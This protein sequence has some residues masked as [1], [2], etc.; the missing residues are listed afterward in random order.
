MK[1]F[2]SLLKWC[3]GL[4]VLVGSL[5]SVPA[6]GAEPYVEGVVR[7]TLGA[8]I[9]YATV[10]LLPES[11]ETGAVEDGAV[12][13]GSITDESG[14]YRIDGVAAGHYQL[15]CDHLSFVSQ[16]RSVVVR[17]G[18]NVHDFLLV[19]AAEAI[20]EVEVVGTTVQ[21]EAGKYSIRLAESAITKNKTVEETLKMLPGLS[22]V[23][24]VVK[25]DGQPVALVYI[26]DR[27]VRDVQ[28]LKALKGKYIESVEVQ[29]QTGSAYSATYQGGIVR[30]KLKK[31]AER[32]DIGSVSLSPYLAYGHGE[33][34]LS[35]GGFL[36]SV[37]FVRRGKMN[38]YN[39][40]S[41]G[42]NDV[43][44]TSSSVADYYTDGYRLSSQID[45]REFYGRVY[46]VFG[47]V[48]D[49]DERSDIG[50]TAVMQLSHLRPHNVTHSVSEM[51]SESE[52]VQL[53]GY[54]SSDYV[55]QTDQMR[56]EYLVGFNYN[57]RLDT[58]GSKLVLKA[59]Y[60]HNSVRK[61]ELYDTEWQTASG[62][63]WEDRYRQRRYV[64]AHMLMS[65][66]DFTK[67]LRAGRAIDAGLTYNLDYTDEW[68]RTE[69]WADDVWSEDSE[70]S[71]SFLSQNHEATAYAI[72]RDSYDKFSYSVGANLQW[73]RIAYEKSGGALT[74]RNY[75]QPFGNISV[76]YAINPQRGT[77]IN[78]DVSRY[79]S[80][81]PTNRQLSTYEERLSENVYYV[82]NEHLK[83][84]TGYRARLSYTLRSAWRFS[85]GFGVEKDG[86]YDLSWV[87]PERPEVVWQSPVNG[88]RAYSHGLNVSW[89]Q[90]VTDWLQCSVAYDCAWV[91][92]YY[93]D[94][95]SEIF[96][97]SGDVDLWFQLPQGVGFHVWGRYESPFKKL[98]FQCNDDLRVGFALDR[99][100]GKRVWLQ[101]N[102]SFRMWDRV[103]TNYQLD[104]S[105][106]MR[107]TYVASPLEMVGFTLSYDFLLKNPVPIRMVET[108]QKVDNAW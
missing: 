99:M 46:D 31:T 20:E 97:F 84:P 25:L 57:R 80:A 40:F 86:I 55:Q 15:V 70:R 23:D 72:Y 4:L 69:Q 27:E 33:E 66:L 54:E 82:G 5:W 49:L 102:V 74:A 62:A 78:L 85:Y 8:G 79:I 42:G 58:L 60:Y 43:T 88:T 30:I 105:Y 11:A 36:N 100:I 12:V 101:L 1:P 32:S 18:R 22:V 48:Y 103:N 92:D 17:S 65:R 75:V 64:T 24:G 76:A 81:L 9:P 68:W 71:R 14:R 37:T 56:Q 106:V 7:D 38:I 93:E 91:R 59:D 73:D 28:E 63:T 108:M 77:N 98:G 89:N 19:P 104:G 29:N 6:L 26:D 45:G 83:L 96:R 2:T 67:V 51:L 52:A 50:V 107:T 53:P 61:D 39:L 21:Y 34:R 44:S 41:P 90:S 94:Y 10:S 13:F 35:Y 87:D 3:V 16:Q 47:L 95:M